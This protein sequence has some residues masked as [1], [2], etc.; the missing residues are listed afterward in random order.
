MIRK[1]RSDELIAGAFPEPYR[2]AA[3]M[4]ARSCLNAGN[5]KGYGH[6]DFPCN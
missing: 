5:P 6:L 4:A 1:G 3:F 2:L